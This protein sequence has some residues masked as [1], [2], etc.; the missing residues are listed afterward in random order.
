MPNKS[1][2]AGS[3]TGFGG[4]LPSR[5]SPMIQPPLYVALVTIQ[6]SPPVGFSK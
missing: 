6:K 3:G 4:G 5:A 1:I 2:D